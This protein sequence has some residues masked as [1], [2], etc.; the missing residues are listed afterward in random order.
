MSELGV[1][2]VSLPVKDISASRDFYTKMGFEVYDDHED[3]NWIILKNGTTVIGL[4]QGMFPEPILTFNPQD[5]RS[6]QARLKSQGI[7]LDEE[8]DLDSTG[9]A[10]ITLADPDG[11]R[12][13]FDQHDP[14]YTPTGG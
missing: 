14:N 7:A 3:E 8:A 12:I 13:M 9:P 1:F 11:N 10:Y 4:F 6:V 5:V 2:S